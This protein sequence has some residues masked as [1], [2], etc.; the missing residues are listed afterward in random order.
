MKR[1]NSILIRTSSSLVPLAVA[2]L[3]SG[4]AGCSDSKPAEPTPAAK[5]AES[6]PAAPAP[7]AKDAAKGATAEK[8]SCAGKNS[9]KGKGGCSKGDNGCAGKNSCKGKGGCEVK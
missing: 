7:A 2:G 9:C 8:H 4:L 1:S 3:L 6:K 5:P